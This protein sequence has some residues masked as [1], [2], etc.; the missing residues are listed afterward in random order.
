M[1]VLVANV[2]IYFAY[3]NVHV[4]SES[5][6]KVA[7]LYPTLCNPMDYTV[8]GFLQAGVLEWVTFHSPGDLPDSGIK[9]RSPTLQ[10][11]SLPAESQGKSKNTGVGNLPLLQG[12]FLTQEQNQNL[13]YCKKI[14]YQLSIQ[15]ICH[16]NFLF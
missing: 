8:H 1:C 2:Y 16:I 12:I 5:E 4:K 13:L 11:D 7:Q 3:I 10:A 14:L 6:V 15:G 9:P